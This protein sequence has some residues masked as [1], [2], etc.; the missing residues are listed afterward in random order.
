MQ[1]IDYER[2]H[3]IGR[4]LSITEMLLMNKS[5][6]FKRTKNED[7][8]HLVQPQWLKV[9]NL[10]IKFLAEFCDESSKK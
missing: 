9:R 3:I 2:Q 7:H 8:V 6:V 4:I 5:G 10:G 1:I